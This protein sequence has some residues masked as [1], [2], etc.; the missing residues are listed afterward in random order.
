MSG[1]IVRLFPRNK[2]PIVITMFSRT[3][4][5]LWSKEITE[6][7]GLAAIAIPGYG[8]TEHAPVRVVIVFADGTSEV[9]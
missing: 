9:A 4:E 2:F 3:G 5:E 7:Q 8:G 1:P 6:P